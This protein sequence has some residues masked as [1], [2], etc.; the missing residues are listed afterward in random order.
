MITEQDILAKWLR[1]NP[2]FNRGEAPFTLLDA[3]ENSNSHGLEVA[4]DLYR[5][6]AQEAAE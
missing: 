4:R 2:R 5:K 6:H 3:V 1:A